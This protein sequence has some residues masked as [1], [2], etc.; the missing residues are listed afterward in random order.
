[1][2]QTCDP[3]IVC[4]ENI[5]TLSLFHS[6]PV[7]PISNK[8]G[9]APPDNEPYSLSFGRERK[10]AGTL[11]FLAHIKDD[12]EHIPAVCIEEDLD[13]CAL[14]VILAVNKAKVHDGD[15]VIH[16]VQQ[17]FEG[18]FKVLARISSESD[19]S[20]NIK[21]QILSM[22]VSMCSC[23]ILSRLRLSPTGRKPL[24]RS[25]KDTLDEAAM[26]FARIDR[27]KLE[28]RSLLISMELLASKVK[29]ARKLVDSWSRYQVTPRLVD[30]V[31]GIYQIYQVEQ[32]PVIVNLIPNRDMSPSARE[33]FL[34]I[35]GK[36]SQYRN[37][38]R[39]LYRTAKT[40]PLARK[41]RTV[42]V[43]LSQDAFSTP[44]LDGY[45]PDLLS[46]VVEGSPKGKQPQIFKEI[47]RALDLG[48]QRA[49][50]Q[51]SR[52]VKKSIKEAKIHAEVQIITYCELR[53][54]ASLPRVIC[55]SK[56]A[57][58]L[59]NLFIQV[60][61]KI[62]TP[63]SHGRLYPGWRLPRVPQLRELE[64]R[65]CQSLEDILRE[66]RT[67]LLSAGRKT[68]YP[69]PNESTLFTLGVSGT[70]VNITP[71]KLNQIAQ[72]GLA[73]HRRATVPLNL[74]HCD[75]HSTD[76]FVKPEVSDSD[77][78]SSRPRY[79]C[80]EQQK[81]GSRSDVALLQGSKKL[82]SIGPKE[83]SEFYC[84]G[85]LE[86]QVEC[87]ADFASFKYS[88]EWLNY[89]EAIKAREK[90]V[91]LPLIDAEYIEGEVTLCHSNTLY[92]SMRD[93]VLK[94]C[95]SREEE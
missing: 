88:I 13:S 50:D 78:T 32:L 11:A 77:S 20:L 82:D 37:A 23:R 29:E 3:A 83:T 2:P 53:S 17:G 81:A 48:E 38:A 61:K 90:G 85:S 34:N 57:C 5:A 60:Y 1:M 28:D 6:I 21:D 49:T 36:V 4:A 40:F 35:V 27:R 31:H 79:F 95:W 42:P 16:R 76:K 74:S 43:H 69:C 63:R 54:P 73:K 71:S 93:T 75:T 91:S 92:I 52:Q 24:K 68:L 62:Y 25:I 89:E 7:P 26:A 58:F 15:G 12:A 41:M 39:F 67:A 72:P 9:L 56:D 64:Q 14:N 86:M 84:A 70:T 66:S 87:I 65:F 44:S 47:C 80:P 51:F 59:C 55:S 30:L 19:E 33:S 46:K 18:I 8:V 45:T 94:I 22:V 10:L